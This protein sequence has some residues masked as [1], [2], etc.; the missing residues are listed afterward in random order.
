VGGEAEI[1]ELMNHRKHAE[2]S[3]LVTRGGTY[4]GNPLVMR[5]GYE[6]TKI[7][8]KRKLYAQIGRLGERLRKGLQAAIEDTKATAYVSG[9]GSMSKLHLLKN[10]IE[11]HDVKSLV[12]NADK[13]QEQGYF[14]YLVSK[15]ILAMTPGQVHF[16]ISQPHRKEEIDRTI[17]AT[18]DFLGAK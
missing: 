4:V 15:G 1:M 3:E 16:F 12:T 18:K 17:K 5:A 13:R 8:E 2:K 9:Y 7:Y 6:A 14:Q 10:Q 11:R